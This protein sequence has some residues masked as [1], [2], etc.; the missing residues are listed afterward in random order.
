MEISSA[1]ATTSG[2]TMALNILTP[3]AVHTYRSCIRPRIRKVQNIRKQVLLLPPKGG[4]GFLYNKLKNQKQYMVID[5]DE[6]L[7]SLVTEEELKRLKNAKKNDSFFELDLLYS[8][9][10]DKVKTFVKTQMKNNK[11]LK[12]L[13]LSSSYTW[14]SSFSHDAVCI[15]APDSEFFNKILEDHDTEKRE[16]IR[17]GRESFLE[18]LPTKS[19]CTTYHSYEEL[20]KMTRNRLNICYAV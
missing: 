11:K 8:S 17:K 4:K 3:L 12:V 18:S 9:C 13:F 15:A 19:V 5:V 2:I 16:A 10:A 20:E 6:Y 1:S 7:T 14:A